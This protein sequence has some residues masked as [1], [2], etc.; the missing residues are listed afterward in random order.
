MTVEARAKGDPGT[1]SQGSVSIASTE[2]APVT[3]LSLTGLADPGNQ[4]NMLKDSFFAS[5][6][7]N[8]S[9]LSAFMALALFLRMIPNRWF[10]VHTL[11]GIHTHKCTNAEEAQ[12][13]QL[14][15]TRSQQSLQLQLPCF[16]SGRLRVTR[17]GC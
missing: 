13:G 8:R 6:A 17:N 12:L 1:P 14:L 5:E 11:A 7:K 2:A 15:S 10:R 9:A 3:V 16:C 4:A